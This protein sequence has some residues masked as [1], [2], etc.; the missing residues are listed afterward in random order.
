MPLF[1]WPLKP[2]KRPGPGRFCAEA[3]L[4]RADVTKVDLIAVFLHNVFIATKEY[5]VQVGQK[6]QLGQFRTPEN[7]EISGKEATVVSWASGSS[8]GHI[9]VRVEGHTHPYL[10]DGLFCVHRHNIK[11]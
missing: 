7:K 11:S 6:V 5:A 2:R 9:M 3:D 8:G 4:R 1:V 10:Q